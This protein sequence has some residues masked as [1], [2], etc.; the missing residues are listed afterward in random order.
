MP[1]KRSRVRFT[2][3]PQNFSG[4]IGS[5]TGPASFVRTIGQLLDMRCNEIRLRKLKLRL[6]DKG[7]ANHKAPVLPSGRNHFSRSWLF[8]AVAPRIYFYLFFFLL[9]YHIKRCRQLVYNLIYNSRESTFAYV[10]ALNIHQW[11]NLKIVYCCI[12]NYYIE[13]IKYSFQCLLSE[14]LKMA[15]LSTQVYVAFILKLKIKSVAL[16]LRRAKTGRCGCCQ[17]AVQAA[18]WLAKRLSLNLHFSFL[19]RISLLLISSSY[20]FVLRRLGGPRSRPYT[21]RKI[22][23]VQPGTEPGTSWM[24]VRLANHY[25]KLVVG[26]HS[27]VLN[28]KTRQQSNRTTT[29]KIYVIINRNTLF[30][31]ADF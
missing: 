30:G 24:A 1:S 14:A 23:G 31:A 15:I 25:T 26:V 27:S 10:H 8:W 11:H 4:S 20:P 7:F 19:N 18:L 9:Y 22:S 3:I 16:Q 21:S 29:D 5:G 28:F 6:K 2:A 13:L 17:M 12:K